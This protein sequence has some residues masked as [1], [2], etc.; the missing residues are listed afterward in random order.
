M[1][2]LVANLV[3]IEVVIINIIF[4]HIFEKNGKEGLIHVMQDHEDH[5]AY[6]LEV[7]VLPNVVAGERL[8]I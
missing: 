1:M 2:T 7:R 6:L 3:I 5:D 8:P 4:D